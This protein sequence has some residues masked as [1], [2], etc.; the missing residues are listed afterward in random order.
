MAPCPRSTKRT[1]SPL[2]TAMLAPNLTSNVL[3]L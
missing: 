2:N 3:T 1:V